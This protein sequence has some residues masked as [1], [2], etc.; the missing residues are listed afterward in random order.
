VPVGTITLW[1]FGY[2]S[3]AVYELSAVVVDGMNSHVQDT[4]LSMLIAAGTALVT[5]VVESIVAEFGIKERDRRDSFTMGL[6]LWLW[7][8][9]PLATS[10]SSGSLSTPR[11][12]A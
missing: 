2:A 11:P 6:I 8:S 10:G 4:V 5:I 3:Y 9:T 7:Q 1:A 12:K